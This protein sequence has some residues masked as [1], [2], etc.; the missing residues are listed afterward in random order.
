V[1]HML[2]TK[3]LLLLSLQHTENSTELYEQK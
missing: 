2:M 1:S 3:Q